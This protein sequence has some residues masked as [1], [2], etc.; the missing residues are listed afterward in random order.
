MSWRFAWMLV[1]LGVVALA[2]PRGGVE[3]VAAAS[4]GELPRGTI[5][6]WVPPEGA[7]GPPPGWRICDRATQEEHPWVPDLSGRFLVGA[8]AY[9]GS[10]PEGALGVGK[11]GGGRSHGH[12]GSRTP[13]EPG[14]AQR[15]ERGRIGGGEA[16]RVSHRHSVEVAPEDH[17]PPFYSVIY[18]IKG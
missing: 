11:M 10:V 2:F 15:V 18:I 3:A 9:F 14:S 17:L 6:A 8:S 5:L 7:T 1:L 16:A 13:L 12:R 4:A